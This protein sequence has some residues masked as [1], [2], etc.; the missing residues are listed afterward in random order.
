MGNN[1]YFNSILTDTSDYFKSFVDV[2]INAQQ[3]HSSK[4]SKLFVTVKAVKIGTNRL[5]N[6]IFLQVEQ[7]GFQCSSKSKNA[8][9]R[10]TG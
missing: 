2:F 7:L 1:H 4:S 3:A 6:V 10:Q 5:I 8:V 9:K